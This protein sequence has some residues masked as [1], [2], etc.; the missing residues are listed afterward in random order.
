MEYSALIKTI[1]INCL[2]YLYPSTPCFPLSAIYL[3]NGY[4]KDEDKFSNSAWYFWEQKFWKLDE[5]S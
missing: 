5:Q 2:Q 3:C 1:I 4:H